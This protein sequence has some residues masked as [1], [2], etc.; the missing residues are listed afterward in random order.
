VKKIPIDYADIYKQTGATKGTIF[1]S[2]T[3][4]SWAVDGNHGASIALFEA[5]A[6]AVKVDGKHWIIQEAIT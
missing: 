1:Y 6:G 2:K 5:P 4:K 3:F